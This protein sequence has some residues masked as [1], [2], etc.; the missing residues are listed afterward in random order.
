MRPLQSAATPEPTVGYCFGEEPPLEGKKMA[1]A[2]TTGEAQLGSLRSRIQVVPTLLNRKKIPKP[3][4]I[5]EKFASFRI[6]IAV[7]TNTMINTIILAQ[8]SHVM[9]LIFSTRAQ[10]AMAYVKAG[11]GTVV[12]PKTHSSSFKSFQP[13]FDSFLTIKV[14]AK[15]ENLEHEQPLMSIVKTRS[16]DPPYE[17]GSA[18]R[19]PCSPRVAQLIQ[20]VAPPV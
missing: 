14:P 6:I 2:L 8:K 18:P 15:R 3:N 16:L 12:N 20:A 9:A 1:N 19:P 11:M 7:M 17:E 5:L 13:E 4:A 10:W